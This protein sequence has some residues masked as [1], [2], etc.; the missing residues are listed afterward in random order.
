MHWHTY[1]P[2][3]EPRPVAQV[4]IN[5]SRPPQNVAAGKPPRIDLRHIGTR[6]I[7]VGVIGVVGVD[8]PTAND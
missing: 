1:L 5:F 4:T 3:P 8:V 6:M 7:G 2:D